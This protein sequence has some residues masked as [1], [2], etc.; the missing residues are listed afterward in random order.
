MPI[1]TSPSG[2]NEIWEEKPESYLSPEECISIHKDEIEQAAILAE[3]VA[4]KAEAVQLIT[5]RLQ[6]SAVQV[7]NFSAAEF[8]TLA[9]AGLFDEWAAGVEY[10]F[11]KRIV[12]GGI[13]YEVK[14]DL[15]SQEH[16]PPGSEGMLAI[17]RP[18]S[19]DPES[20]GE[21]AGTL[22]DPIA[23]I[24]GMDVNSG[25]YY[26]YGDLVYLAKADMIPC[27]WPPNSTGLWQWEAVSG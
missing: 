11:G 10:T 17:Y 16:Q 5:S 7:E 12:H 27:V 18:L 8:T 3:E 14:Q 20:G 4:A 19:A 21:A 15:T 22:D 24:D 9:K 1:F 25:R 6:R 2:N 13:V 23:F 26:S